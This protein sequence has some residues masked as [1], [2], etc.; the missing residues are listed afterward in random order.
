MVERAHFFGATGKSRD[1][2]E[3]VLVNPPCHLEELVSMPS[4]L[5][6][7][8]V[9]SKDLSPK[10]LIPSLEISSRNCSQSP[11]KKYRESQSCT[12]VSL[13]ENKASRKDLISTLSRVAQKKGLPS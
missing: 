11:V 9:S 2:G 7:S 5:S 6:F 4:T 1:M 8:L 13:V 3:D 12:E 10:P